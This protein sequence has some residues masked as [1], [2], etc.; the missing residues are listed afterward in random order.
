ME[1]LEDVPEEVVQAEEKLAD[2]AT[3][4]QIIAELKA[5][6][7]I[8]KRLEALALQVRQ[9]GCDRKWE[10][11]SRLLQNQGEMFDAAGHRCKL[12]IF[13]EHKDTLLYLRERIAGLLGRSE[14]VIAIH[15]S[16]G[17]EQAASG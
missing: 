8:L 15:G 16:M 17:G 14:A 2:R 12:I 11:L 1:D 3:V 10:K 6:I 4:A 7:S 13:T 9:S 5:E